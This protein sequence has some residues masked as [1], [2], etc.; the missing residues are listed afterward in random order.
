[1][2]QYLEVEFHTRRQQYD[3]HQLDPARHEA[4]TL[5]LMARFRCRN[6]TDT[7]TLGTRQQPLQQAQQNV[8][9]SIHQIGCSH[10]LDP[11]KNNPIAQL[12]SSL[13]RSSRPP[14]RRSFGIL[15]VLVLV[16]ENQNSALPFRTRRPRADPE[17]RRIAFSAAHQY[18]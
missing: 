10:R 12:S 9:A 8:P 7:G 3:I 2:G 1:M 18:S 5:Q 16:K 17:S 14:S 11:T 13:I 15:T 4:L 6:L